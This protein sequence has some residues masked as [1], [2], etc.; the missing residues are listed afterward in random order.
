MVWIPIRSLLSLLIA[1]SPILA[2]ANQSPTNESTTARVLFVNPGFA[3]ESFWGDVDG[4]VDGYAVA[5]A[6][7]LEITL[8]IIHGNRDPILTQQLL[9]ARV[10]TSP[11]PDYVI[12]VNQ[13]YRGL[14][15]LDSLSESDCFVT[16][17]L[18]DLESSQKQRLRTDPIWSSRLLPG[19]IPNNF[20][21]GYLTAKDLYQ[22]GQD[23]QGA[24]VIISGDK[25]TPASHHREA[26]AMAFVIQHED[27]M[28][29]Q[30]V[31]G[32]WREDLAYDQTK[33]LLKRH[34]QAHYIW[35]ANDHMAFGAQR[36]VKEAGL[37]VGKDVFISTINT[38]PRVL[39]EL[40]SGQITSL[41]GGHF[42]AVGLQL[43]KIY[44]HK[45][46]HRWPQRTKFNLFQVIGYP[47]ALFTILEERA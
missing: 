47:S 19:L 35:T 34:P 1:F 45:Q 20:N 27:T 37:T 22:K 25:N 28:V 41:G 30:R 26:G 3:D 17:V 4:D 9:A 32:D 23:Q 15:L 7:S 39:S 10:Q 11:K 18:N 31:Y 29:A 21:I 8:E 38:S 33:I 36:A 46:E 6:Q 5:A 42:T 12:L 40:K 16:F 43:V 14:A 2:N 13:K 24:F 44:H